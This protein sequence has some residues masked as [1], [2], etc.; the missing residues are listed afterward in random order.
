MHFQDERLIVDTST[1]EPVNWD[2]CQVGTLLIAA[3][4]CADFE[5][6]VLSPLTDNPFR[7]ITVGKDMH[8]EMY[9]L[10]LEVDWCLG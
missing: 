1:A 3:F 4:Y 5:P 2:T 7:L 10:C 6:L 9:P 8:L